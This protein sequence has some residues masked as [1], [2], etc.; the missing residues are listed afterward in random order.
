[1][2][3]CVRVCMRAVGNLCPVYFSLLATA[4][5]VL[6]V[7]SYLGLLSCIELCILLYR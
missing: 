6:I 4:P 2:T 3:V 1:M 5:P 7:F